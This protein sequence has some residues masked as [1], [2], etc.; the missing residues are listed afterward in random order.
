MTPEMVLDVVIRVTEKK[1]HRQGITGDTTFD[2]DL[3]IDEKG[4]RA[5]LSPVSDEIRLHGCR[6]TGLAAADLEDAKTVG[7]MSDLFAAHLEP[8]GAEA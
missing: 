6:V 8:G 2:E 5:F 7:E 1:T 4:R 3:H